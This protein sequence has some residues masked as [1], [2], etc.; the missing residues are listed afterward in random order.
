M[1]KYHVS[2]EAW[3]G[4]VVLDLQNQRVGVQ[5]VFTN[6]GNPPYINKRRGGTLAPSAM[7]LLHQI[8]KKK[9]TS[10]D[11]EDFQQ[12]SGR[13]QYESSVGK[14]LVLPVREGG[15][16]MGSTRVKCPNT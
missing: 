4:M 14:D 16:I 15:L 10:E 11:P 1:A 3:Q 8:G 9:K 6:G 13:F 7:S 2:V 12:H 5:M